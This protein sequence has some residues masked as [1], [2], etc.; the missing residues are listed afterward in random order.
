MDFTL[1]QNR[2]I[3]A[4]PSSQNSELRVLPRLARNKSRDI[5]RVSQV[6]AVWGTDHLLTFA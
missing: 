2:P 6:A 4:L 5:E 3:W 1:L